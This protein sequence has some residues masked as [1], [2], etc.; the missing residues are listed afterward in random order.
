[1]KVKD[2][3]RGE[4]ICLYRRQAAP[5]VFLCSDGLEYDVVAVY[6]ETSRRWICDTKYVHGSTVEPA[7]MV[8]VVL[9]IEPIVHTDEVR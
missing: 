8:Q 4:K 6:A 5:I 2:L 1:M 3:L 9:T 7:D